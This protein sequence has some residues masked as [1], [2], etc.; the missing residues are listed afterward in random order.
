MFKEGKLAFVMERRHIERMSAMEIANALSGAFND[1]CTRKGP[2]VPPEVFEKNEHVDI[3][4][5][6]LERYSED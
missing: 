5:S 3:C 6:S 2:S 1:L 4:G